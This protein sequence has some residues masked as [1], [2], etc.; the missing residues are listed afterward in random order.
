[1]DIQDRLPELEKPRFASLEM[2]DKFMDVLGTMSFLRATM[3]YA[4]PTCIIEDGKVKSNPAYESAPY[5]LVWI[6]GKDAY[7]KLV[8]EGPIRKDR[9]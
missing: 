2:V 8:Y 9:S 5:E 7:D 6:T 3:L 4:V 1:M